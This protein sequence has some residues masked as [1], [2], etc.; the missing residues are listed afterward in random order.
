MSREEKEARLA[1][2]AEKV[3]QLSKNA[4]T[5]VKSFAKPPTAIQDVL[6]ATLLLLGEEN[7]VS[8]PD[9]D[10]LNM[11]PDHKHMYF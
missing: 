6:G 2:A 8:Y 1:E 11:A 9:V 7:T 10:M 4:M 5:E 3:Q